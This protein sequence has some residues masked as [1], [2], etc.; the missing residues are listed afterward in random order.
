MNK[1]RP[2]DHQTEGEKYR[3]KQLENLPHL[4][5]RKVLHIENSYPHFLY[6]YIGHNTKVDY[7]RSLLIDSDFYLS[8]CSQFNDPFDTTAEIIKV[9]NV[10]TLRKKL[11]LLIQKKNPQLSKLEQEKLVTSAM[12][13]IHSNP[14]Y[15]Y[16]IFK[17]ICS[18]LGYFVLQRTQKT[19]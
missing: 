12:V 19:F 7:L 8:S 15:D 4:K 10:Q 9:E 1:P 3:L 2:P 13:N 6:K 17:K 5:K 18:E 11:S 14:N 16:E